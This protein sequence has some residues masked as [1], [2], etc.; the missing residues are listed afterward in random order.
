[1][2]RFL[3]EIPQ[4][5]FP[6]VLVLGVMALVLNLLGAVPD[7]I[8]PPE[9]GPR[10]YASIEAAEADLGFEIALPAYFPSYLSWPPAIIY[11]Q[12]EPI[13]VVKTTF[14]A[15]Y[16][17]SETLL[18]CQIVSD[19]QDLPVSLPWF[20]SIQQKIPV[21]IGEYEGVMLAG[22]GADGQLLNGAYWKADGFYF[23]VVTTRS[24][25]EVLTIARSM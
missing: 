13:P 24:A 15:R 16:G 11:G 17:S 12:R 14:V 10:E 19:S 20:D 1:M 9:Y 21:A 3:K 23:I 18:V 4:L 8:H 25:R 2:V 7:R 6:P 5:I 22:T